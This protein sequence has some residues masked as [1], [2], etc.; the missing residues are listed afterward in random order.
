MS[1]MKTYLYLVLLIIDFNPIFF[2]GL[3]ES[4]M[5]SIS[6]EKLPKPETD[7]VE[8][9]SVVRNESS[10]LVYECE[11]P[12]EEVLSDYNLSDDEF[13]PSKRKRRKEAPV[14]KVSLGSSMYL[15]D[16]C[17]GKIQFLMINP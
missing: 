9:N 7:T 10:K 5:T 17:S 11:E 4:S 6:S 2:V 16:D 8:T 1:H 12:E 14:R 13:T 15:V 3:D